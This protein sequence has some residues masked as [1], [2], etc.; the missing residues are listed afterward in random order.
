MSVISPI[1]KAAGTIN[2]VLG[3]VGQVADMAIDHAI[4]ASKPQ[5]PTFG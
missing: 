5:D 4:Q 1:F 3:V 2:P